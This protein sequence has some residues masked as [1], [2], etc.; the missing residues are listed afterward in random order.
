M[1][2]RQCC[3]T[4]PKPAMV[5]HQ[6]LRPFFFPP[7]LF[8]RPGS[9]G[10]TNGLSSVVCAWEG[11]AHLLA[12]RPGSCGDDGRG[13]PAACAGPA[14]LLAPRPGSC[15][16]EERGRGAATPLLD[17]LTAGVSL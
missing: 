4:I 16:D 5:L 14:H 2:K 12:P 8:L 9:V 11:A 17:A 6:P 13:T 15:G 1:E 3:W 7:P 10:C